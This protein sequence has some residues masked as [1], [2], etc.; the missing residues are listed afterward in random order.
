M[1]PLPT[2]QPVNIALSGI[3]SVQPTATALLLSTAT[4][5]L[6]SAAPRQTNAL[7]D[8]TRVAPVTWQVSGIRPAFTHVFPPYSITVLRLETR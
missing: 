7:D 5:L 6:L 2:P 1:N 3:R 4:A 8:P